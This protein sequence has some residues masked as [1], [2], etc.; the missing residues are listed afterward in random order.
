MRDLEFGNFV[1][2]SI[3]GLIIVRNFMEDQI[4][5]KSMF[6]VAYR[7]CTPLFKCQRPGKTQDNASATINRDVTP[8][9]EDRELG[10]SQDTALGTGR[11]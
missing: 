2:T 10:I 1:P 3:V 4:A 6:Y 8:A 5:Q 9:L 7:L 11:S